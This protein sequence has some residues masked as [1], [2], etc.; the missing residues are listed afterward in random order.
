MSKPEN[1]DGENLGFFTNKV[2]EL[3]K[4]LKL[5]VSPYL[6]LWVCL[7]ILSSFRA[8]LGIFKGSQG[9]PSSKDI[10]IVPK[11]FLKV[12]KVFPK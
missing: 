5:S 10:Q 12:Y 2:K 8:F 1:L 4:C 9:V 11:M 3:Q 6:C 7:K